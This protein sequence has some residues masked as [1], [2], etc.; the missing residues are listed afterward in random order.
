MILI[1]FRLQVAKTP[2]YPEVCPFPLSVTQ[3]SAITMHRCSSLQ[4]EAQMDVMPLA[5]SATCMQRV[6]L[7]M[8]IDISDDLE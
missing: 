5:I 8:D 3:R 4:T 6:A 2:S 7:K 1:D